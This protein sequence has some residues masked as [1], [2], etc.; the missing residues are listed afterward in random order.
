MHVG[1]KNIEQLQS[2]STTL[3]S[4]S[5]GDTEFLKQL[6]EAKAKTHLL[7][8]LGSQHIEQHMNVSVAEV[9]RTR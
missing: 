4:E 2:H 9:V 5:D 3:R 6:R 1:V 8:K 7:G